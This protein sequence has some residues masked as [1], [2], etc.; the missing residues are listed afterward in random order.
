MTHDLLLSCIEHAKAKVLA[1][2]VI[3]LE[4]GTYYAEIE[5]Q[6]GDQVERVD[7]RPS[8]AIALAL[9][10]KSPIRV[11][12]A[13]LEEA[14]VDEASL[15][16]PALDGDEADKWTDILEGFSPEDKYKM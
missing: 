10:A 3:K 14:S 5:L 12:E 13:V 6:V 2:E 11:E 15:G 1:V 4:D 9:R 7:A 8:D 16:Q